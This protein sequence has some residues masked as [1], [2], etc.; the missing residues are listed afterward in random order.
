MSVSAQSLCV[1][2]LAPASHLASEQGELCSPELM[3][4]AQSRVCP[5]S[6][7]RCPRLVVGMS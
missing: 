1:E 5:S 3:V 7:A 6:V 2:P 4:L